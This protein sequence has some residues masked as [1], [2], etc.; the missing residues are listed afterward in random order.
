MSEQSDLE[1]FVALLRQWNA[2]QNL[3]SRETVE[4]I[5]SRHI[6]DSLQLMKFVRD[7][8][9]NRLL[10]SPKSRSDLGKR[11]SDDPLDVVSWM[12]GKG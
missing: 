11:G 3:V 5:W 7:T 9:E 8:H 10:S 2:V 1:R 6:Q 4:D 12:P